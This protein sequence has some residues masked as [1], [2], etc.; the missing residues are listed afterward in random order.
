MELSH[1]S[2]SCNWMMMHPT[3][4]ASLLLPGLLHELTPGCQERAWS[5]MSLLCA[6]KCLA[7]TSLHNWRGR[8]DR[9][10]ENLFQ[11]STGGVGVES[12]QETCTISKERTHLTKTLKGQLMKGA[13]HCHH[14][15]PCGMLSFGQADLQNWL[16]LNLWMSTGVC[17]SVAHRPSVLSLPAWDAGKQEE[18]RAHP[19]IIATSKSLGGLSPKSAF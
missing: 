7:F 18:S 5:L 15:S 6:P 13:A 19:P 16:A 8:E 14:G 4:S 11:Y 17:Q 12:D 2:F 3:H 9:G 1:S 10:M